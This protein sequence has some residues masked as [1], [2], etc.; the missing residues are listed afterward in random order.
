MSAFFLENLLKAYIKVKKTSRKVFRETER[1][2]EKK[3]MKLSS[4]LPL[5]STGQEFLPVFYVSIFAW[6]LIDSIYLGSRIE[7]LVKKK[8][9]KK[10]SC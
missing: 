1:D 2:K 9:K 3:S 7:M 8:L 6:K 5:G 10:N 4:K